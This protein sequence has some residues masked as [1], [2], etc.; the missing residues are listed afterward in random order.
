M[1]EPGRHRSQELSRVIIQP[2]KLFWFYQIYFPL[3]DADKAN[4]SNEYSYHLITPLFSSSMAEE[5]YSRVRETKFGDIQ[6]KISKQSNEN[7]YHAHHLV[8]FSNLGVQKFGGAQ[9]QNISMLNKGRTFKTDPNKTWGVTYLLPSQPPTW[10]NQLKP[11]VY[12]KSLFDERFFYQNIKEDIDYLR[13]FL[14]RFERIDLSVKNPERRKWIER[15]LANI[16]DEL[17]FFA[18]SIQSLPSG[19]TAAEDIK[20]KPAHQYLL[21][22]YRKDVAFQTVRNA[23]DWQSVV[24]EDFAHWLNRR[25]LGK[26][27]KFTPQHEHRRMWVTLLEQPLREHGEILDMELKFQTEVEA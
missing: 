17:L 13:D 4:E 15:W 10:K 16:I 5:V 24:C 23:A 7:K 8:T 3:V 21:D 9:P 11:P 26:D 14:L 1:V 18:G 2:L 12:T 20:L 25:L 22:P 6:K 19:W 27:K